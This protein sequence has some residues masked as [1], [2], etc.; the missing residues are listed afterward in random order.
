MFG[1]SE[2]KKGKKQDSA[3]GVFAAW[4]LVHKNLAAVYKKRAPEA[5]FRSPFGSL[6]AKKIADKKPGLF[7][8]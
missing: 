5:T 7:P 3:D 6:P 8:L 1:N 2:A 4:R